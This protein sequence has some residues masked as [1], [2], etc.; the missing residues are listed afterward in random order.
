MTTAGGWAIGGGG[1][2][3][4]GHMSHLRRAI[5]PY[6][7]GL[8][9]FIV[10]GCDDRQTSAPTTP[11]AALPKI[12]ATL[13]GLGA[14]MAPL[15]D[16]D[17]PLERRSRIYQCSAAMFSQS[18]CAERWQGHARDRAHVSYDEGVQTLFTCSQA[19]CQDRPHALCGTSREVLLA[20]DN[21]A[22]V[23]A[24]TETYLKLLQHELG[25]SPQRAADILL[26]NTAEL[27]SMTTLKV[28]RITP[29]MP[30]DADATR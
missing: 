29:P 16:L 18:A 30:R 23:K 14:C 1:M 8:C 2:R 7:L 26:G 10:P 22:L 6:L 11:P 21:D 24:G 15:A 20:M 9:F 13:P 12:P 5:C 17:D 4:G 25:P 3:T 19:Y 28:L 27:L